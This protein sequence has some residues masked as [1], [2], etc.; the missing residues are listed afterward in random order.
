MDVGRE[1]LGRRTRDFNL[2]SRVRILVPV[3]PVWKQL[4]VD[5]EVQSR[6]SGARRNFD[7]FLKAF[8]FVEE[9]GSNKFTSFHFPRDC[10]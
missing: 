10:H 9:E 1:R 7:L 5:V 4:K 3:D 2:Q 8:V 6:W